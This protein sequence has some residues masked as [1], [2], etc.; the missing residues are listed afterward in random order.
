VRWFFDGG[1]GNDELSGGLV[2]YLALLLAVTAT[3]GVLAAL[4]ATRR[5]DLPRPRR[6]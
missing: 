3:V 6:G 2:A 1:L 4:L 5:R